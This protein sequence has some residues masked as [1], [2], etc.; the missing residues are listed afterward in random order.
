[1]VSTLQRR[2][3]VASVPSRAEGGRRSLAYWHHENAPTV[4]ASLQEVSDTLGCATMSASRAPSSEI[5]PTAQT[6][7]RTAYSTAM[8]MAARISGLRRYRRRRCG[9]RCRCGRRRRRRCGCRWRCGRRCRCGRRRRGLRNAPMV[10][11]LAPRPYPRQAVK[12]SSRASR[13]CGTFPSFERLRSTTRQHPSPRRPHPLLTMGYPSSSSTPADPTTWNYDAI[14]SFLAGH[15]PQ[16]AVVS[17]DHTEVDSSGMDW[18]TSDW[19]HSHDLLFT[20]TIAEFETWNE[21]PGHAYEGLLN[22]D[23]MGLAGH[24]HGSALMTM[25]GMGPKCSTPTTP[26]AAWPSPHPARTCR[27]PATSTPTP[28]P[29]LLCR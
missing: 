16:V 2:P 17:T 3:M 25:Q 14:F 27:S 7:M 23:Q 21:T 18:G 29:W 12:L 5:T 10:D 8:T 24:S 13:C 6:T 11:W 28:A 1:M 9:C 22:F 15:G 20:D 26:F 4:P 19:W